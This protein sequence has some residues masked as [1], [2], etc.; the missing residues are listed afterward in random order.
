MK[1]KNN[2]IEENTEKTK[3]D[4][5]KNI[6]SLRKKD[7]HISLKENIINEGIKSIQINVDNNLENNKISNIHNSKKKKLKK[8]MKKETE[9]DTQRRMKLKSN[10]DKE[11]INEKANNIMEYTDNEINAL[12]Y[13]QAIR[14]DKRTYC[15]FY[16]SL[17]KTNHSLIFTFLNN[18]DY[19]SKIIK[20]D[21]FFIGFIADYT[22]NGLFF[23]EDTMHKI[24]ETKG[25]LNLYYILY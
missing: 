11:K 6:L 24:Y 16:F 18:N 5:N 13:E 25:S 10:L 23:N 21:I 9:D 1:I 14:N 2:N 4:D 19:N 17:L 8:M 22:I 15:E 7:N 3:N 12:S 20:I